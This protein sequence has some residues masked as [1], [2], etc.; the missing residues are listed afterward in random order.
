MTATVH[1]DAYPTRSAAGPRTRLLDRTDPVVYTTARSHASEALSVEELASYSRRGFLEF[2]AFFGETEL[3]LYQGEL[4]RL[5]REFARSERPEVIREPEQHTVRSIFAV[6]ELSPVFSRLTRHPQLLAIAERLLGSQVYV[7]QSRV[8]FKPGFSGEP[9]HWH[10]DFETWHAEDG[11]PRMRALSMSIALTDNHEFN[12][13]LML[14]PGSHKTFV[15]CPGETPQQNY[16]TS[17][18]AQRVGVPDEDSLRLLVSRGGI[19][20]HTGVAGSL[21]IFDS[22][23]MHASGGN[24]T[25]YPRSN[26]F[27]VFNS[28]D[29]ALTDPFCGRPPRPEFIAARH[30]SP[31]TAETSS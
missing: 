26:V 29:N 25:P 1:S 16:I 28:V 22:N 20:T 15:S 10:S 12:G 4:E 9:F 31:L 8:N 5:R 27:L 18:R 11:M 3:A 13:P 2:D 24:I 19:V 7:H 30:A 21:L 23:T 17:L 14:V 6:H